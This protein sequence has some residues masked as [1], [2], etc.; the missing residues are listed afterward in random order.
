M[1]SSSRRILPE[2]NHA[3]MKMGSL[4]RQ[5]HDLVAFE[6]PMVLVGIDAFVLQ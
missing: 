5:P 2:M 1:S 6:L 4:R 3:G